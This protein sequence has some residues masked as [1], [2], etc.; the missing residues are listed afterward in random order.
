MANTT[1]HVRKAK[2]G[3]WVADVT[4]N[5]KRR[6]LSAATKAMAQARLSE[7]LAMEPASPSKGVGVF[8]LKH[9]RDLSIRVRW[10]LT[11]SGWEPRAVAMA[12]KWLAHFGASYPLAGIGPAQVEEFR[13]K[14]MAGDMSA[15][16]FNKHRAVMTAMLRDANLHGH[17]EAIPALPPRLKVTQQK[18]R[19]L[20]DVEVAAF[21]QFFITIGEPQAADL[22]V[23]LLA[24]AARW[25]DAARLR[26]HDVDLARRTAT[27]SKTK[28][29]RPR[30]VPLTT[31]GV[32]ALERWLPAVPAHRVWSYDY[33]QFRRL[34]HLAKDHLG[35]GDDKQ[36]TIHCT[37]HTAASKMAQAGVA[38]PQIAAMGGWSGYQSLVRYVHIDTAKLAD[39][40]A[41]LEG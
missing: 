37:R 24:T 32:D 17:L 36:L 8:T 29:N 41:A 9:A 23:F 31:K 34:W 5:G 13:Q 19:I 28:T 35:L 26:G 1:G 30:T 39:C 18:D 25:S 2:A 33:E 38:L 11:D 20:S 15:S 21:C 27:F 16:T 40:V 10:S 6:Q 22:M 7:A 3:G 14:V 12:N 4:I